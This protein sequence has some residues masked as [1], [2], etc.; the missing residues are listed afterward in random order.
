MVFLSL[1][2]KSDLFS[3]MSDYSDRVWFQEMM[4]LMLLDDTDSDDSA[5]DIIM[6]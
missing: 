6:R 4:Q 1:R 3:I 2:G 5:C